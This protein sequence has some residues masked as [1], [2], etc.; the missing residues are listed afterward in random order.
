[1]KRLLDNVLKT[2]TATS[3]M[4]LSSTVLLGVVGATVMYVGTKQILAGTLTLGGFFTYTL[5]LGFLVAPLFQIVAIGTQLTRRSP[6]S[7]GRAKSSG[8]APRTRTRG[9]P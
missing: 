2:L 3:V 4:S 1:V 8:N 5:F 9:G 7:S 6:A